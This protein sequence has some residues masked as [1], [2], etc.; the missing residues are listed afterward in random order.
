MEPSN[1]SNTKTGTSSEFLQAI[2]S[3]AILSEKQLEK[4]EANVAEG[5]YPPEPAELASRLVKDGVLTASRRGRSSRVSPRAWSSAATSSSTSSARA[6]W[7]ASTRPGT[8]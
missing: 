3:S 6:G 7:A 4:V 1:E 8:G 2:R 5:D